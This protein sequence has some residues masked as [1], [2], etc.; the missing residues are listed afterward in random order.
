[1]TRIRT[2]RQNL[3]LIRGWSNTC[4]KLEIKNH[5][6]NIERHVKEEKDA[7]KGHL[8]SYVSKGIHMAVF[9]YTKNNIREQERAAGLFSAS[10]LIPQQVKKNHQNKPLFPG[11]LWKEKKCSLLISSAIVTWK[12]HKNLR[13]PNVLGWTPYP[14]PTHCH[15]QWQR[16]PV[17]REYLPSVQ[18]LHLKSWQ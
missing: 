17:H 16:D 3:K 2:S 18:T 10:F 13:F 8:V 6:M 9:I 5:M 4:D 12:G 7:W 11:V 1:M 15:A 14:K